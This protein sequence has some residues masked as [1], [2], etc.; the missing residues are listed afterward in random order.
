MGGTAGTDTEW[1][2]EIQLS[3]SMVVAAIVHKSNSVLL[4]V[5]TRLFITTGV[6]RK[7]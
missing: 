5:Y 2:A 7:E 1:R 3:I 6:T 4:S